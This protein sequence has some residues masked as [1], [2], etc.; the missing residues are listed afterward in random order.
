[1]AGEQQAR[2]NIIALQRSLIE[3][4]GP[5]EVD[6]LAALRRL[7]EATAQSGAWGYQLSEALEEAYKELV[8]V[9][10]T[11]EK[12]Q[13]AGPFAIAAAFNGVAGSSVLAGLGLALSAQATAR[14]IARVNARLALSSAMVSA[15]RV[16]RHFGAYAAIAA[17]GPPKVYF[18]LDPRFKPLFSKVSRMK[19]PAS[20]EML[21]VLLRSAERI[22][23]ATGE[24]LAALIRMK[25]MTVNVPAP[26]YSAP[27]G[28]TGRLAAAFKVLDEPPRPVTAVG[29]G[30]RGGWQASRL[31][32]QAI[33]LGVSPRAPGGAAAN[34]PAVYGAVL[35]RPYSSAPR[36]VPPAHLAA[37]GKFRGLSQSQIWRVW[38]KIAKRGVYGRRWLAYLMGGTR[39]APVIRHVA[40]RAFKLELIDEM[41]T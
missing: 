2:A 33:Q 24:E 16:A 36:R 3:A 39:V 30:G 1:M 27:I 7:A 26:S 28:N 34:P 35:N 38:W 37:W 4:V 18:S 14:E 11:V 5:V 10:R 17:A 25:I 22:N 40:R 15:G 8:Q 23:K 12:L 29:V 31:R 6:Y 19:E 21:N 32:V 13:R 9:C 20:P 41:L